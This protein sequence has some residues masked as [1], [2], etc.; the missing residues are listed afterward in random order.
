MNEG[1]YVFAQINSFIRKHEFNKCVA[2][3]NGNHKVKEFT[4]WYQFLCMSFGQITYRESL[5]DVVICLKAQQSKAY[6]SGIQIK[7]VLSTLSRANEKRDWRIYADFAQYL[8]KEARVL[9]LDDKEFKLE[10]DNTIY[11]LDATTIDLCLSVFKWAKFRKHKAAI[12]LHTLLDLK[13][14]IPSFIWITEGLVHD[15]NVLD[16]LEFEAGAFYIM[17]RGYVDYER[18]YKI[19][20]A[21]AFFVV[22]AKNNLKFKRLYSNK[23][24]RTTGIICDQIIRLTIYLSAKAYPEKLRRIKFYDE[25]TDQ[26]YV[27]L[28]NNFEVSAMM[29]AVLYK[30]RWKIE[31]FFKWI[32]QHLKIKVFWGESANAVKTQIWIAIATYVLVAIMKK[33]L[34]LEQSLYEILQILSISVF[35]KTPINQLFARGDM[36]KY[37]YHSIRSKSSSILTQ[38]C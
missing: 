25:E 24:D 19:K 37:E 16:I 2:R 1:K 35:D 23:V 20:Q 15:V 22:R 17:D 13:G 10:L 7:V 5:R 28:T 36:Q 27:Y 32:K 18:L 14:S 4:C 8:I 31:L 9:Y 3:Y 30:N 38:R 33:K 6:H 11:A 26:R 12:K 29:I 34:K 21:S